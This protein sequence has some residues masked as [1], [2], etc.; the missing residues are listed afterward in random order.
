MLATDLITYVVAVSVWMTPMPQHSRG[1]LVLYGNERLSLANAEYRGYD[2]EGYA[3]GLAVMSP[4]DLGKTVWVRRPGARWFGPCLAVD[5]SGRKDF[6]ANVYYR[7][8]IAE[9]DIRAAKA[10]GFKYGVR[11]EA[12]VGSCPPRRGT[13]VPEYYEPEVHIDHHTQNLSYLSAYWP[14]P[15]QQKLVDCEGPPIRPGTED[16]LVI[17]TLE[18]H[19]KRC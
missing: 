16:C 17:G 11:G 10:L 9:V 1:W 6:F 3:C 19:Q 14:Y 4:A 5:T 18:V 8:E 12:Y 15:K 7:G 2:I 13:S